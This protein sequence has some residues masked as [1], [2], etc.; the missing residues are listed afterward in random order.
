V[1]CKVTAA[2]FTDVVEGGEGF[3]RLIEAD[4]TAGSGDAGVEARTVDCERQLRA[5]CC[6]EHRTASGTCERVSDEGKSGNRRSSCHRCPKTNPANPDNLTGRASN[7]GSSGLLMQD[8]SIAHHHVCISRMCSRTDPVIRN[9]ALNRTTKCSKRTSK[10]LPPP[11][12]N[13]RAHSSCCL[14]THHYADLVMHCWAWSAW[15]AQPS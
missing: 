12:T 5:G 13:G 1:L 4:R 8:P 10:K 15:R 7:H 2:G 3:S 6:I 9:Y 14:G 11:L